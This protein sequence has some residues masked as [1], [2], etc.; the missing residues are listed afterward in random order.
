MAQP[1]RYKRKKNFAENNSDMTDHSAL[2][3]ELDSVG[4]SV[5]GAIQNLALIQKDDGSLQNGVVGLDQISEDAQESLRSRVGPRGEPGPKGDTGPA[6]PEGPRGPTGASFIADAEG[7]LIERELHDN[8]PKGFSFLAI[9]TGNLFWKV[10]DENADWSQAFDFGRGPE[11]PTGPKGE[12]GDRGDPGLTGPTG[13]KGDQ[14]IPGVDGE[15]GLITEVDT[16]RKSVNVI[17]KRSV[18]VQLKVSGGKLSIEIT[19]EA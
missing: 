6:G 1:V 17:G 3:A 11:G 18:A 13:P 5:N 19:A 8:K 9:D 15:D 14:G 7:L 10:S 2:N 12:K 16:A 4:T